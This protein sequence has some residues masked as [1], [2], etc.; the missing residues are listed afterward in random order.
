MPPIWSVRNRL[1]L[2][3]RIVRVAPPAPDERVEVGGRLPVHRPG[4]NLGQLV[5]A[6]HLDLELDPDLA[7][8]LGDQ[9]R[10]QGVGLRLRAHEQ[11]E[12]QGLVPLCARLVAIVLPARV[13]QDLLRLLDV[14]RVIGLFGRLIERLVEL[15]QDPVRDV[16]GPQGRYLVDPLA[17]DRVRERLAHRHV[18]HG[19][20]ELGV[21][22][23][24]LGAEVEARARCSPGRRASISS[25]LGSSPRRSKVVGCTSVMTSTSP[26]VSARS[27]ASSVPYLMYWISSKFGA[28]PRH[29]GFR[30]MRTIRLRSNSVTM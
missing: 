6:H 24:L 9:L 25:T 14:G 8:H 29:S 12:R 13:V 7:R 22:A 21:G 30:S 20:V 16:R 26:R 28:L 11:V 2:E 1:E 19:R 27:A 10:G 18:L 17:V 5:R 3:A 15:R 4:L 23:V